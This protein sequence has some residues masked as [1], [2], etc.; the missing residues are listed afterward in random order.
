MEITNNVIVCVNLL[1]EAKKKKIHID[2]NRL[3]NELGVPVVGTTA[4]KKKTLDHLMDTI[5]KICKKEIIPKPKKIVYP[6]AIEEG[7]KTLEDKLKEYS[8][9]PPHLLRWIALKLIDGEESFYK[10]R[11]TS[12]VKIIKNIGKEEL[13]PEERKHLKELEELEKLEKLDQNQDDDI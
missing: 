4:R 10:K 6:P 11:P 2:L 8:V 9:F 5:L 3:S 13:D 12:H 1:D 7:I